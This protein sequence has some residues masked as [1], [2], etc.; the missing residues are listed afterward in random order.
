[1]G[2]LHSETYK[3]QP[4]DY[5]SGWS[6]EFTWTDNCNDVEQHC[7]SHFHCKCFCVLQLLF[8]NLIETLNLIQNFCFIITTKLFFQN[9]MQLLFQNKVNFKLEREKK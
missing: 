3:Q 5:I 8:R 4:K 2:S 6:W 9:E 1:M 7:N